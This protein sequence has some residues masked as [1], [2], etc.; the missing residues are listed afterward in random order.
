MK[1]I[2]VENIIGIRIWNDDGTDYRQIEHGTLSPKG[3]MILEF[4]NEKEFN[5]FIKDLKDCKKKMS[6]HP[7]EW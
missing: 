2:P 4:L 5:N 1:T 7:S 3:K 6:T